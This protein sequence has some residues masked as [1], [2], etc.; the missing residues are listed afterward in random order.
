MT[1][2]TTSKTFAL[3]FDETFIE[4]AQQIDPAISGQQER[5]ALMLEAVGRPAQAQR[6]RRCGTGKPRPRYCRQ[7][8]CARCTAH[9]AEQ[10]HRVIRPRLLAMNTPMLTLFR[11][12]SHG[13]D[14]LAAT[15]Q[16]LKQGERSVRRSKAMRGVTSLAGVIEPKLSNHGHTFN[17]HLHA[18]MDVAMLDDTKIDEKF[19]RNTDGRGIFSIDGSVRDIDGLARYLCKPDAQCPDVAAI[20][21]EAAR[22]FLLGTHRFRPALYWPRRMKGAR[23]ALN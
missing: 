17:V 21:D 19:R 18:V 9:R 22:A 8:I 6:L 15:I 5:W 14:D 2:T 10:L 3:L 12:A 11:L 7:R 1:P 4:E 13:L 20:G 23:H 16:C